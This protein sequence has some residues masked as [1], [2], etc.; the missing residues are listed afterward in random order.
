MDNSPDS[1]H[2]R[3]SGNQTFQP[4]R[5]TDFG[6]KLIAHRLAGTGKLV[7][8]PAGKTTK[9]QSLVENIKRPPAQTGSLDFETKLEPTAQGRLV[10]KVAPAAR[11]S[12]QILDREKVRP[13]RGHPNLYVT[14]DGSVIDR[15]RKPKKV[16]HTK[17][18]YAFVYLRPDC[19][20]Y[21]HRLVAHVFI[22]NPDPKNKTQVD[23]IN[24]IKHDN[25]A[26]NLRWAT[27]KEN[28][29]YWA[30]NHPKEARKYV[31]GLKMR[32]KTQSV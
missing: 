17:Q 25:R 32:T 22:S 21:I 10:N 12:L 13:I 9:T 7:K 11:T 8:S 24:E 19:P 6:L 18:G 28:W 20:R 30:K 15:Q 16:Y 14:A 23:H 2:G 26:E 1:W 3:T 4:L 31:V 5:R 27:P 29:G